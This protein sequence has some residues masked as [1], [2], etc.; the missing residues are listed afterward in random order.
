MARYEYK[1]GMCS[2]VYERRKPMAE[3]H[4]PDL[5]SCGGVARR[6][7]SVP[8]GLGGRV[9]A[10]RATSDQTPTV[11]RRPGP[12]ATNCGFNN[13]RTAVRMDGGHINFDGLAVTKCPTAFELNNG[14]TVDLRNT[15]YEP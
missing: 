14:A 13:C 8:G 3:S 12:T 6:L 15:R 1:C 5:C 4:L 7:L 11:V 2:E 9:K 10:P